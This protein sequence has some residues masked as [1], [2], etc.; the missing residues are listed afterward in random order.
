M[1]VPLG[2][3]VWELA[4]AMLHFYTV[5]CA[6]RNHWRDAKTVWPAKPRTQIDFRRKIG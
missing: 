2:C 4:K 5:E 3:L 6:G 1:R